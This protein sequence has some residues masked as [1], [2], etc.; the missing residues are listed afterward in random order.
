MA[1]MPTYQALY[2]IVKA[3]IQS[4]R[5]D[6]TD[7]VEGSVLDAFA[8][9][10]AAL[11]DESLRSVVQLFAEK[12]F[13]TAQGDALDALA[14]DFFGIT[15]K[16]ATSATG[17]VQWTRGD[18]EDP[19]T[20]PA[21]AT[22]RA[23]VGDQSFDVES[24]E[25]VQMLDGLTEVDIPCTTTLKGRRTNLAAGVVDTVVSSGAPSGE[26]ASVTNSD[27][28]A[29]GSDTETD[30]AFRG[31]I[32]R[33]FS[34]LRKGTTDAIAYGALSV[35]GVSVVAV[36]ESLVEVDQTVRVYIGDPDARSNDDLVEA[37]E[38]E[39]FNWKACGVQVWVLGAEREEV[40]LT[41]E[42][43]VETGADLDVVAAAIRA[44]VVGYGDTLGAGQGA[45]VSRIERAVQDASD[46]VLACDLTAPE[47]SGRISPSANNAAI[48]F[49]DS[50][51]EITFTVIT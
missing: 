46:L 19:Y 31:R 10:S 32:R 7:F 34:T 9:A 21:G 16:N 15:R 36:D 23:R 3:A 33:Y 30:E 5:P 17:V 51:I 11:A 6:L 27:P 44:S 49:V 40:P 28:F 29:G 47:T 14:L 35:P 22:F 25:A 37:V 24:V 12:F 20:I 45:A 13:S 50:Q 38:T 26:P 41:L 2:E 4:R 43:E 39:L 48:R 8:G 42:V 1:T 18:E